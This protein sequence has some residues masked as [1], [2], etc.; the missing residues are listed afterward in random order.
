MVVLLNPLLS[1]HII[2]PPAEDY[3]IEGERTSLPQA[4]RPGEEIDLVLRLLAPLTPGLYL[5]EIDLVHEEV[6]WFKKAGSAAYLVEL[7]VTE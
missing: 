5:L 7:V 1:Y 6:T 4:V 2:K 3:I